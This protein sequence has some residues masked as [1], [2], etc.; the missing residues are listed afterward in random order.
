MSNLLSHLVNPNARTT[1]YKS[2]GGRPVVSPSYSINFTGGK[3][4]FADTSLPSGYAARSVSF[5]FKSS[6]TADQCLFSYGNN[7]DGQRFAVWQGTAGNYQGEFTNSNRIYAYT[8]DSAWHHIM[9]TVPAGLTGAASTDDVKLYF[10][11]A[12][13]SVTGNSRTLNT[14]LR[15]GGGGQDPY[16]AEFNASLGSYAFQGYIT[17]FRIYDSDQGANLAIIWNSGRPNLNDGT[18]GQVRWYKMEDG[19]GA[20]LTDATTNANATLSGSYSWS[21]TVP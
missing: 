7:S 3:A 5:W 18:T 17:D 14:V 1:A 11:G 8:L 13:R 15:A 21:S 12:L 4:T 19:S 16:I 2:A 9:L 20:T 6:G 10:D